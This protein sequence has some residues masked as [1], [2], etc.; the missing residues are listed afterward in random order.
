MCRNNSFTLYPQTVFLTPDMWGFSYTS[1]QFSMPIRYSKIYSILTLIAWTQ[2]RPHRLRA[3]SHKPAPLKSAGSPGYSQLLF[4]LA[5]NWMSS[6]P[7]SQIYSSARRLKKCRKT[8]YLLDY[9]LI[10]KGYNSGTASWKRCIGPDNGEGP[11]SFHALSGCST[12]PGLPYVQQPGSSQPQPF[13]VMV[14]SLHRHNLL[15]H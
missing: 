15:I 7:P 10:M 14:D 5:T 6:Q 12:L 11:Q 2:D 9:W 8:V 4:D 3:Q 13:I 1:I